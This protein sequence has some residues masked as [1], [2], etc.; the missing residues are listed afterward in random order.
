[1]PPIDAGQS[2]DDAFLGGRLR[3]LQPFGGYR[4]GSDAVLLAAAV[5]ARP[6]E[7]LLDAGAGVGA[8][9]LALAR[10]LDEV[11][12]DALELQ[13]ELVALAAENARRNG[14]A[15]RVSC[16]A[17]DLAAPPAALAGR[18]YDRVVTN[19]PYHDRATTRPA[20]DA[21]RALARSEGALSIAD[22]IEHCLRRLKSGGSL[23]LI[24]RA[25]RLGEVLSALAPNAGEQ[26]VF[27]L[28]PA[29]GEPARRLIVR[30]R[31]GSAAP[32]TLR[33]GLVLHEA[34]GRYTAAA[35]AVLRHGRA[36]ALDGAGA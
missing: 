3:L 25:D 9:A 34:D 12:V 19:P 10:R 14:L 15:D 13:P 31:K 23:T 24:Q 32:L 28:W 8:V 16:H 17:G 29:A 7:R 27:P 4:A 2:S 20:P 11:V 1:M 33:P 35:E 6:G 21:G 36:L 26:V 18:L 30:A 5:S 22:W